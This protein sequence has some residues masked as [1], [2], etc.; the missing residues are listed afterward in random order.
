L[1]AL[2]ADTAVTTESQHLLGSTDERGAATDSG[3]EAWDPPTSALQ[4]SRLDLEIEIFSHGH[5]KSFLCLTTVQGQGGVH[6]DVFEITVFDV[7]LEEDL[8]VASF[9]K[10]ELSPGSSLIKIPESVRGNIFTL[11]VGLNAASRKKLVSFGQRGH[12]GVVPN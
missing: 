2:L 1:D 12:D 11:T 5:P 7:E 6:P 9:T 3:A 10:K 4:Q 8:E